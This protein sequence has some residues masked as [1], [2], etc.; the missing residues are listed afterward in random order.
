M[1]AGSSECP[2]RDLRDLGEVGLGLR[3]PVRL[4]REAWV[5]D[6]GKAVGEVLP[7]EQYLRRS[8]VLRLL[9]DREPDGG[10][11]NEHD[12]LQDDPFPPPQNAEIVRQRRVM[13]T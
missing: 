12:R 1:D 2:A 8:L 3:K 9:D 13:L 10:S 11:R 7:A 5:E 4:N 6:V